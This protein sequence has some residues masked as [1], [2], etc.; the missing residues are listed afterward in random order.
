MTAM[1]DGIYPVHFVH[2]D[3]TDA[4]RDFSVTY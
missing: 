1:H 2:S 4:Y 3:L